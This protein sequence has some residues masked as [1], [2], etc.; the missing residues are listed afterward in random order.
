MR[1]HTEEQKSGE[2][3]AY[4][5]LLILRFPLGLQLVQF[6]RLLLRRAALC[7]IPCAP[8]SLYDARGYDGRTFRGLG[9]PRLVVRPSAVAEHLVEVA[10]VDYALHLFL[11]LGEDVFALD[12]GEGQEAGVGVDIE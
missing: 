12:L 8:L 3:G 2:R 7:V 6:L 5:L 1:I 9:Y 11:A 4:T 10:L